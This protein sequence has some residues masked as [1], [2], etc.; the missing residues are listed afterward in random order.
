MVDQATERTTI[1]APPDKC[2]EAAIAFAL[3]D[4]EMSGPIREFIATI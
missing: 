3:K 2:F 1:M 4:S